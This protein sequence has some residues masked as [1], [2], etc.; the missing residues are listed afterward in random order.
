MRNLLIAACAAVSVAGG[1]M[2]AELP[3]LRV[4]TLQFG[5]VNWELATISGHGFD[6]ARGFELVT[7]FFADNGA[8]RIAFEGGEADAAVMDWIWVARQREAGKD[9]VFIPYS[10]AVGGLVVPAESAAE[11]L[12]DLAGRKIGVAG[13]PLD[14]SWLIL[15]AYGAREYGMDLAVETEQVFAAPP[16]IYK[17]GLSG[18]TDGAINFWHFLAR[19]KARG[20][21]EL[22]SV[23]DAAAALGLDP[24]TPLLGYV[25]KE[26]FLAAH[27]GIE[28]ALYRASR[29]AKTLLAEDDAAWEEIRPLMRVDADA[30]FEVMRADFRAGIP[31][32]RPVDAAGA[33]RFLRLMAELGGEKLVGKASSLPV[34]LFA[35]V[36]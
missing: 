26:S 25:L 22:V 24:E 4:A 34:G 13:G 35:D 32:D 30:E 23:E 1:A 19:M 29:D 27:P 14:K 17:T 2:A 28:K 11:T 9:Y 6:R 15:R 21:R 12:K 31:Q 3:K 16:L 7:R 20:M 8:T 5:T 10:K 36:E 18:E 33:D